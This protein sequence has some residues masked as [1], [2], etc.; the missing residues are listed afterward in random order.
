MMGPKVFASALTII[1]PQV[2]FGRGS[3]IITRP[4]FSQSE[5]DNTAVH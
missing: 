3:P 1:Q 2:F 5:V 4:L